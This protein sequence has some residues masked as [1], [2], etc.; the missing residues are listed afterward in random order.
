MPICLEASN[1][2]HLKF[3][4]VP[5]S[6]RSANATACRVGAE[7]PANRSP[8]G[9]LWPALRTGLCTSQRSRLAAKSC[10]CDIESSEITVSKGGTCNSVS[11][12]M[13]R[14]TGKCWRSTRG[15]SVGQ[16]VRGSS[17][18]QQPGGKGGPR[19]MV[20]LFPG[21]GP[22]GWKYK[23]QAWPLHSGTT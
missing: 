22:K 19:L 6:I 2:V 10:Q 5:V 8:G 15:I 13:T 11:I 17:H 18:C 7:R 23:I 12:Q 9:F 16:S 1:C 4:N 3:Y 14:S 21:D 20:Q